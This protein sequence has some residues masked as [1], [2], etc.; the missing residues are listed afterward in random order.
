MGGA[1]NPPDI[2]WLDL[3][4]VADVI[5]TARGER[6]SRARSMWS[7]DCP[8]EQ[9]IEIRFHHPM[10][11]RRLRVVATE[12][13]ASRTQEMT[14]WACLHCGERHREVLRQQFNFS[15]DGA[16]E[17]IEDYVFEFDDVSALQLRIVPS[18]EGRP[19]TAHVR[20]LRVA[21]AAYGGRGVMR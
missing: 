13:E 19:A 7:A 14:V 17:E 9:M 3:D 18:V 12:P 5:I 20:E 11:V 8:G 10:V 2:E 4:A 1:V 6:L 15:P 16:T 21:S